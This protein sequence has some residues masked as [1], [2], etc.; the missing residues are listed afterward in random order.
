MSTDTTEPVPM[1]TQPMKEHEWLQHLVGSWEIESEMWMEPD[2]P[3]MKGTGRETVTSLN[4]LWAFTEGTSTTPGGDMVYKAGL[5]FDVSFKEYRGFWVA[6]MSSHLWKYVGELSADGKTMTLTCEGPHMEKDGETALYR[7]V[8]E[9]VDENHRTLTSYG[10]G[11][12]GE[13]HAFMKARY[14]RV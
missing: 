8:I 9:I 7:D 12:N 10:Q 11:D 2:A 1:G 14:R 3:P 6:D 4:G 13:W 5:G